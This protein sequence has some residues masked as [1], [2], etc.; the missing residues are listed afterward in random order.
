MQQQS[1][2]SI[3]GQLQHRLIEPY[4]ESDSPDEYRR[5][6][7]LATLYLSL[8]ILGTASALLFVVLEPPPIDDTSRLAIQLMPIS[9][10]G[11]FIGYG[12]SRYRPP[13]LAA[14]VAVIASSF[15]IY[16]LVLL[17]NNQGD[18][19]V[20]F[21]LIVPLLISF[22]FLSWRE[23]HLLMGFNVLT[24]LALPAFYYQVSLE[25]VA[26]WPLTLYLMT[27]ACLYVLRHLA[28]S[29]QEQGAVFTDEFVQL[30]S[31][32]SY[33]VSIENNRLGHI[34]WIKG[35]YADVT[36]YLT[37]TGDNWQALGDYIHP[38][39]QD[40]LTQ[41]MQTLLQGKP[42]T[43]EFRIIAKS[44]ETRWVRDYAQ[45]IW[46]TSQRQIIAIVGIVQDITE[47]FQT[48]TLLKNHAMQQAVV[49]E[50]GQRIVN[51]SMPSQ[52][53][54][55]QAV[56]LT[57]QVLDVEYCLFCELIENNTIL[58]VRASVGWGDDATPD[59][60]VVEQDCHATYTVHQGDY[61]IVDDFDTEQRFHI[62]PNAK[63]ESLKSAISVPILGQHEPIGILMAH[64]K[65]KRA[66][67]ID[68]VSF[69]QSI[70]N[71]LA[72][73][74]ENQRV[75]KAEE[76]QRS[77]AQ[78]LYEV[79]NILNT[80]LEIDE[81]LD[82]ILEHLGRVLPHD[83]ASII[84]IENDVG[85][86]V[87]HRGLIERGMD[88]DVLH[89][90]RLEYSK[91]KFLQKMVNLQG[92]TVVP[93]THTEPGWVSVPGNDW[94]R[95]H[96]G[97]P[98]YFE[99]E[100]L[101]FISV[102]SSEVG[103]F[104]ET[105]AQTLQAFANQASIAIYNA[106]RATDLEKRVQ[107]RTHELEV[108]RLRLQNILDAT[109]DGI[110]Y[111][112]GHVI[113]YA[114]PASYEMMNAV[115]G[116]LEGQSLE[117]L[118][119]K[120]KAD[121]VYWQDVQSVIDQGGIWRDEIKLSRHDETEFDAGLTIS[122]ADRL[123]D[124]PHIV[125]LVRDISQEKALEAQKRRFIA[126][127]SHELRS[128][129]SS[130]NTRLYVMRRDPG[131]LEKHLE[132]LERI[133]GRLNNL[134]EDL[135]DVSR[136]ENG[137]ISLR[138]RNIVLQNIITDVLEIQQAEAEQ[139]QI[140][141]I[142]SLPEAPLSVY[143]DPERFVQVLTNLVANA[144]NYTEEDGIVEISVRTEHNTVLIGVQDNG[145]GIPEDDLKHIFTPFYRASNKSQ[146]KGTGL[147]LSIVYEIV[148]L[149]EGDITVQSTVGQGSTF[150]VSLPLL[151]PMDPLANDGTEHA[152]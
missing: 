57:A 150:C 135:L 28:N 105:H 62:G 130:L 114:N 104:N 75:Q 76:I 113:R 88:A 60:N 120:L 10:F 71:V 56:L 59:L 2:Q 103:T 100:L 141:L 112:E 92:P 48:E 50:L 68:D 67:Y 79:A 145:M 31:D 149:H 115:I 7:A 129:I 21:F 97:A 127:A 132:L 84:V 82:R 122:L 87:R 6:Q 117:Q 99:G 102:D 121:C 49:A 137:V 107:Q 19:S 80:T 147:G 58:T 41:H 52:E 106:R 15:P 85:R 22:A 134:V 36:G 24:M 37:K 140:K 26:G 143:V 32:F 42:H 94:I 108:E 44:G 89:D 98:I 16:T 96:V 45:P 116:Q 86:I 72:A 33:R 110:F 146:T 61:V 51:S 34:E 142:Q 152:R 111:V 25:S 12:L 55:E 128:P 8:I 90:I 13:Y 126:N 27:A 65:T 136:F 123:S 47:Q 11:M 77:L 69:L 119:A 109:G 118:N 3:W 35:D 95:A 29:T 30:L 9:L 73:Y 101:G 74:I 46:N 131:Q 138:R 139:K 5:S 93:D 91:A 43:S 18:V 40:T 17:A 125:L 53:V 70:A 14:W 83:A 38:D 63:R 54:Y 148:R 1:G 81:V 39:D 4:Y 133:S 124:E 66:F 78:A 151:A 20:L 144:I 64:S 23:T